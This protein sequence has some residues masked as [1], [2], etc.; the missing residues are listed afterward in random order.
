M[1]RVLIADDQVLL[2]AGLHKLIA[3]EEGFDVVGEAGNG[4]EAAALAARLRPDVVLMDI[5]M[6]ILDGIS[7]TRL[8]TS[9]GTATRVLILT[10]FGLDDYV[11]EALRSG[12]SGFMLKDAP[13]AEL[14][15]AVRI[16]AA[17]DSILAPAVTRSVVEEFVRAPRSASREGSLRLRSLT[18]REREVFDLLVKG[19][20]NTEICAHLVISEA[21]TKTHVA[22]ILQK[23]GVRDRVQ[24]VIQAYEWGLAGSGGRVLDGGG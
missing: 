16:I 6:P 19:R 17:G 10:T 11:F 4:S 21:T 1:I 9:S 20:S 18:A 7:A 5:R 22:R 14:L 13:A 8:I 15:A 23:I 2:R 3:D 12:A 24:V